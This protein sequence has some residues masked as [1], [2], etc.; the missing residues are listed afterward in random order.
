[1]SNLSTSKQVL[2]SLGLLLAVGAPVA[3]APNA[4]AFGL[5]GGTAADVKST[6]QIRDLYTEFV[7]A[8][9][10][11]DVATMSARWAIDGDQ[12]E[13]DGQVAKGRDEVTALLTKQ[14]STVFKNTKLTL[15][16]KSVWMI[17]D[18]VAL[19]DGTYELEGAV[20]PD[21]TA[22]PTR[23]GLLT[24]VLLKERDKWSIA[25]SRLMIPTALPYK[26][27]PAIDPSAAEAPKQ[28]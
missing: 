11:H 15:T 13:P 9:N 18:T 7:N 12:V 16:V 23:K 26:P 4:H 5:G 20:L 6:Q 1:M 27:K 14:H 3:L 28:P 22:I 21:G 2:V 17:S 10:K 25:A 24:S 8:W 19:V